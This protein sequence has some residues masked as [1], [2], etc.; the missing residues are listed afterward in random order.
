MSQ[1]VPMEIHIPAYLCVRLLGLD[2]EIRRGCRGRISGGSRLLADFAYDGVQCG[3][4]DMTDS[5][6]PQS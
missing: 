3:A 5:S 1:L 6:L 4:F 2:R